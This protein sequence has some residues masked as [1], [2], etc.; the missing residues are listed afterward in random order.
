[1]RREVVS[2]GEFY[3]AAPVA[4]TLRF[5]YSVGGFIC[6]ALCGVSTTGERLVE[7][8]SMGDFADALPALAL[9]F[10]SL[11]FFYMT[12]AARSTYWRVTPGL[13]EVERVNLFGE[14]FCA[15]R[16]KDVRWFSTR[17]VSAP[18]ESE[19]EIAS[20]IFSR[21]SSREVALS[22]RVT[23]ATADGLKHDATGFE[24][25]EEALRFMANFE[26]A[27]FD[28]ARRDLPAPEA[29]DLFFDSFRAI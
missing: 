11:G 22:W 21:H 23:L 18:R 16:P 14:R 1:M 19:A 10:A 4:P 12:A 29:S 20:E 5:T 24:S 3:Y 8:L 17:F 15:Y 13:I 28:G 26:A 2:P 7:N 27:L 9:L 25:R 6:L